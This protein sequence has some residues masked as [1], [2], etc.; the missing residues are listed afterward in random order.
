MQTV[1]FDSLE[2]M[3]SDVGVLHFILVFLVQHPHHDE[4]QYWLFCT[5]GLTNC[6]MLPGIT[7]LRPQVPDLNGLGYEFSMRVPKKEKDGQ[8]PPE[9]P[10]TVLSKLCNYVRGSNNIIDDGHKMLWPM[11]ICDSQPESL[12]KAFFFVDDIELP[13]CA[14]PYG[15]WKFLQVVGCTLQEREWANMWS[16]GGVV[17]I[18]REKLDAL[19][20][21]DLDRECLSCNPDS[22]QVVQSGV[23][24]DGCLAGYQVGMYPLVA[25][26]LGDE[27]L[28]ITVSPAVVKAAGMAIPGRIRFQQGFYLI[29]GRLNTEAPPRDC[30][31]RAGLLPDCDCVLIRVSFQPILDPSRDAPEDAERGPECEPRGEAFM[32]SETVGWRLIPV[33]EDEQQDLRR[34]TGLEQCTGVSLHVDLDLPLAQELAGEF[35]DVAEGARLRWMRLPNLEFHVLEVSEEDAESGNY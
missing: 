12:I 17:D 19:L 21:T 34:K 8:N 33:D 26:P 3:V 28:C 16:S 6:L 25:R 11:P 20:R 7:W 31:P 14:S 27:G 13:R 9:W 18:L 2:D 10:L 24:R 22:A 29:N 30:M 32:S 35:R 4:D 1:P 15:S 5:C 23:E